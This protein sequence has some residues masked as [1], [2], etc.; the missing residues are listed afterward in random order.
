MN[1]RNSGS[2][3]AIIRPSLLRMLP[4]TG[5]TSTLSLVSLEA[6]FIQYSRFTVDM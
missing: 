6:T 2:D 3:P 5:F 1:M 4:L